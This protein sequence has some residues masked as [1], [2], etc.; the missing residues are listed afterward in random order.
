MKIAEE[1]VVTIH[2]TLKNDKGST[3]ESSRGDRPLAYIHGMG[4]MIPGLEDAL[5]GKAKGDKVDV[6]LR[7]DQAYG[8]RDEE[9]MQSIPKSEF[10][11]VAQLKVGE[12]VEVNS[13]SGPMVLT[14]IEMKN[15]HIVVDG[16]H[17]FAGMSLHFDVEIMD[18]REATAEEL[19]HGH[20]HGPGGH[21]HH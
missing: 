15:D 10:D 16:N 19:E 20:V 13:D 14:V 21:H 18:V 5:T 8:E 11:S 6:R 2:F 1:S 3:L 9:M 4:Q 12:Q 17:P 7:P